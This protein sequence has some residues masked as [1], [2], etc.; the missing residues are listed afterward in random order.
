MRDIPTTRTTKYFKRTL[1]VSAILSAINLSAVSAQEVNQAVE[2][3][4]KDV[5]RIMVTASKRLK[6]LQESPVAI[7]V[8]SGLAVDQ[9]KVLDMNDLQTLVPTLRVT[10]LQR[11]INTNFAIRGFGNGTNNTGIEPSVGIFIDGVYRSRAA[12]QIGDLPRLQQIEVLSGPQSTLFGKNASAGVINV[13]TM[14]PA[15][16]LEGSIELGAGNFNQKLVKGYITNGVTEELAFSLSGGFNKRDGYTDSVVGLNKINNRDRWNIRGQALYEPTTDVTL[17]VIADYSEIDEACCTAADVINGPTTAAVRALGG[18]VL[19]DNDPFS[20]QSSLNID[21]DNTVQDGG[22]S[23]QLDIDFDGFSFTSISA[24]RSNDSD[25]LNDVDYTSLDI[26][27]EGGHTKIDTLTQEFRLTSTGK[28]TLEWMIGA[29][30]F[31]E[32]VI[33]GDTLYYGDDI[34]SFF[35]ALMTAGGADGLLAGVE[36]VYGLEQGAFFSNESFVN[37]EFTQDNDAYSLFANFDYHITED[38]TA[39]FGV[40]YTKDEKTITAEQINKDV[41][42][43]LDIDTEL[44]AFGVPLSLIPTLAPAIPILNSIQLLPPMPS[45]PNDVEQSKSEDSKTTWSMRL[46][47]EVNDNFNVF[48][49]AATGFK[50]SSWNLGR[51]S[52]PFIA[53]QAAM[54]SAGVALANQTY[55]GRFAS[56][57]EAKVYELGVKARFKKGA[58]NVTLFDQTIEGFQSS[59]F[60]G[61]GYVLA[62]AGKQSTQ[63][64]EFDSVYNPTENWSFTL[65]GTFLDP[66]YDSFV[67]ATGLDGPVDLSG[68][69]PAGIHERS[70]TAGITYSYELENGA[71]GYVRTDYIYESEVYLA[72]NVPES[73]TREVGTLNATAGLNFDNG[74]NVQ[75]WVRNLNNDEYLHSAFPPPIQAGSYN[76]YPSQPRMYGASISYEF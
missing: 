14:E 28:Q 40:S 13:R 9:A 11:S 33:T 46:A 53:D 27:R 19:E 66:V 63:G 20:Y 67:G 15:H 62:N 51:N 65:A 61:T 71:Y 57:E 38:F 32:E 12:A 48:A 60:I 31:Q 18:V 42:S 4:D 6:G 21:P 56:P 25:F 26:L 75:L 39:I 34:R 35:D 47:Y 74:L 44:T 54:E 41:L 22:V 59:I 36:Q 68:E 3:D 2:D 5:E 1:L 30:I 73:L 10:P 70:I 55:G 24:L 72:E 49:T 23:V 58:F 52:N 37:S 69:K 64:L 17:R 45:L 7:T 43:G 16:S 50:A 29:Y 76:A 8:V